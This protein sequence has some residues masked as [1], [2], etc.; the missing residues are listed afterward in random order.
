MQATEG[1][2]GESPRDIAQGGYQL[3][4][5]EPEIFSKKLVNPS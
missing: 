1:R 2:P 4:R 5:G 3:K